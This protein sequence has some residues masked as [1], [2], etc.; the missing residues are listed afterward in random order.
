MKVGE[1]FSR[2]VLNKSVWD[3]LFIACV[4]TLV[5]MLLILALSLVVLVIKSVIHVVI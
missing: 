1:L 5:A 2:N 3:V 4:G